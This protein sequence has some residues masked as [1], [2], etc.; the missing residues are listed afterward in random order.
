M[1]V[2]YTK[3]NCPQCVA[4]KKKLDAMGLEYDLINVDDEPEKAEALKQNGFKQLPVVIKG[5]F[6]WQGFRP[7]LIKNLKNDAE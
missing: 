3:N 1:I 4:T 6:S 2:V 7:D 5:S